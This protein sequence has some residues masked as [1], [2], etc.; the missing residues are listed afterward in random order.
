MSRQYC[1]NFDFSLPRK[2]NKKYNETWYT[3]GATAIA[4]TKTIHYDFIIMIFLGNIFLKTKSFF[5]IK[6]ILKFIE[7]S[8]L[9]FNQNPKKKLLLPL[10]T[11]VAKY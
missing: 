1:C 11:S 5:L 3:Y 8:I 10:S 7:S 9:S 6:R 2:T 4:N